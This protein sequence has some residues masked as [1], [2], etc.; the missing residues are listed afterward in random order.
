MYKLCLFQ[1][2]TRQVDD[3]HDW[4]NSGLANRDNNISGIPGALSAISCVLNSS[5]VYRH[6]KINGWRCGLGYHGP[7][8][9]LSVSAVSEVCR[10]GFLA[11]EHYTR[12]HPTG[13]I[14]RESLR[15]PQVVALGR[16]LIPP[17]FLCPV[18]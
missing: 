13:R 16:L 15:V 7:P 4:Y 18:R 14:P 11:M 12:T 2:Y 8:V 1:L 17:P 5:S 10:W 6:A 9:D 3:S